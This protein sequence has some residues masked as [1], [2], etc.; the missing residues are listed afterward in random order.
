M[1]LG[2]VLEVELLG[3]GFDPHVIVRLE[4]P[5]PTADWTKGL[6]LGS[7][8]VSWVGAAA[9]LQLQVFANCVI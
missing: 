3:R 4:L 5:R 2:R 6:A 1:L 9:S 8:D 7:V